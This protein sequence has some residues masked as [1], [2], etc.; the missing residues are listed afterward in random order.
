MDIWVDGGLYYRVTEARNHEGAG[1]M[2]HILGAG[3]M[4]ILDQMETN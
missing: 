3:K 2:E 4:S 1:W